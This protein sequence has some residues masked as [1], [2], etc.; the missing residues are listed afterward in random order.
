M[1]TV[2]RPSFAVAESCGI[3]LYV[4]DAHNAFEA[5]SLA[6]DGVHHK[7][8]DD[9]SCNWVV[10]KV[11]PEQRAEVESL[12]VESVVSYLLSLPEASRYS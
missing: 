11:T 3:P 2:D 10:A 12:P 1:I 8:L 9:S 7:A 4:V 5:V 6:A